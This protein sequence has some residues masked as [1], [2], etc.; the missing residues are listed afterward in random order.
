M[1]KNET[2]IRKLVGRIGDVTTGEYYICD[3]IFNDSPDFHGATATILTPV[4]SDRKDD[5]TNPD[6]ADCQDRFRECWQEAVKAGTTEEGLID[7]LEQVLNS[8]G[9]EAAFDLGGSDY[10]DDIRKAEPEL[11]EDNYP[12]FECVGGGRSFHKNM[13]FDKVYNAV[14]LQQIKAIED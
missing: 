1:A 4:S 14:L 5:M 9:D 12:I 13:Q 6:N 11:T 7:W 3:Y 2:Q 10:W 8:A